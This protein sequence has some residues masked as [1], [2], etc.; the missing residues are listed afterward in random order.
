[1]S[2]QVKARDGDALCG[3]AIAAGFINCAPLRA[4]PANSTLLSRPLVAGDIVTVPDIT[5]PNGR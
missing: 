4:D 1:M 2:R 5:P 3:I